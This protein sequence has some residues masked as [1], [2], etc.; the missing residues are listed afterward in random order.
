MHN[1]L[2]LRLSVENYKYY[3]QGQ[4]DQ[5]TYYHGGG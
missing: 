5:T 4:L 1:E 3:N 2:K